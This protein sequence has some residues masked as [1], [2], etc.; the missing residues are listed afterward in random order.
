MK[1]YIDDATQNSIDASLVQ[2]GSVQYLSTTGN[3][4]LP[5]GAIL[6]EKDNPDSPRLQV[7]AASTQS[8]GGSWLTP[9]ELLMQKFC[10][11]YSFITFTHSTIAG[12]LNQEAATKAEA[13]SKTREW[14]AL[15]YQP[16]EIDYVTV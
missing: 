10:V 8:T 14:L 5:V 6:L 16:V 12:S 4:N 13:I 2:E 3:P 15:V 11:K 7:T 1:T 9:V